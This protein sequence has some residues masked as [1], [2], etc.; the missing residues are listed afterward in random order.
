M[1]ICPNEFKKH[2]Y[3]IEL[4]LAAFIDTDNIEELKELIP[5]LIKTRI[6]NYNYSYLLKKKI[7]ISNRNMRAYISAKIEESNII[8]IEQK[9]FMNTEVAKVR[10]DMSKTFTN[11]QGQRSD[12]IYNKMERELEETFSKSPFYHGC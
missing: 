1:Q 3:K 5:A 8:S 6:D 9:E 2:T 11:S 4:K 10:S 12:E 7:P